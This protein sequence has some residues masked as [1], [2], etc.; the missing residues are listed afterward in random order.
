MM[1][2]LMIASLLCLAS[3]AWATDIPDA[4]SAGG[5]LY[6]ERCSACHALPHPKRLDWEGWRHM[7]SVMKKR[8]DEK[9]MSMDTSEWRKISAYL[10]G[11]AR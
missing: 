8:M 6:A 9:G 7:L 4:D 2:I 10:K 5:A 3:P 1:R 11:H